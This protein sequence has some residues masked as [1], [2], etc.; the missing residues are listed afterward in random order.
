MSTKWKNCY[1]K[2][3]RN[4]QVGKFNSRA[5]WYF[6][7]T[8]WKS[9]TGKFGDISCPRS[10]KVY[11]ENSTTFHVHEMESFSWETLLYFMSIMKFYVHKSE[12]FS[13]GTL[14]YFMSMRWKSL[15]GELCDI[16]FPQK[17]I[18]MYNISCTQSTK[19]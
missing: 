14:L 13:S 16:S 5:L 19:G 18:F 8:K 11:L 3:P 4:F 10:G 2:I 7:S 17:T 12:N 6:T 1:Q 15:T 9:L